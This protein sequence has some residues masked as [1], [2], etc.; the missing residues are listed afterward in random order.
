QRL[1]ALRSITVH[2]TRPAR[3]ARQL[4]CNGRRPQSKLPMAPQRHQPSQ[5]DS[6]SFSIA[7]TPPRPDRH[8]DVVVSQRF[9]SV[10]S[11]VATLTF[12]TPKTLQWAGT[13][14]VWD[15]SSLNWTVNGGA[16]TTNYTETDNVRLDPLGAAQA[17]ISLGSSLTP[18]S[19]VVSNST[20]TLTSG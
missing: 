13:G 14:S 8:Y 7:S 11:V 3:A 15:T 18:G 4:F 9:S 12:Y 5:C 6:A 17:T 2:P 20:Y 1:R 16:S 19:I 10:P